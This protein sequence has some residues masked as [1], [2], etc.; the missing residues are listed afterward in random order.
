MRTAA[1]VNSPE[2]GELDNSSEVADYRDVGGIKVPFQVI[3]A[4]AQ[5]SVTIKL[6]KVEHNVAIDDAIF[7][8]KLP[9]P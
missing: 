4:N 6:D 2:V 5:Q 9:R 3:N 8:A 7:S 1:R